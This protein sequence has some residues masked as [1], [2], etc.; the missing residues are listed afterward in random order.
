MGDK[1]KENKGQKL[2]L[3]GTQDKI[4]SWCSV[5]EKIIAMQIAKKFFT[6]YR[7]RRLTIGFNKAH[8]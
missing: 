7:S 5:L 4:T 2:E 1:N 6:C 8:G 3:F